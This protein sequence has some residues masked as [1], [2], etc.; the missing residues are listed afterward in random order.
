MPYSTAQPQ[1]ASVGPVMGPGMNMGMG[2]GM[3]MGGMMPPGY[4]QPQSKIMMQI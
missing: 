2:M 1:S 4:M 3:G